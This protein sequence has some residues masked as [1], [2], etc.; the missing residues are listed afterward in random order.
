MNWTGVFLITILIL[1]IGLYAA[2]C[3]SEKLE[4]RRLDNKYNVNKF[5]VT[6]EMGIQYYAEILYNHDKW[7][8]GRFRCKIYKRTLKNETKFKDKLLKDSGINM[9]DYDYD[10]IKIVRYSIIAYEEMHKAEFL[11]LKHQQEAMKAN[12][13]LF[14]EWDGKI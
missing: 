6:S 5:P 3:I 8:G 11:K 1:S 7:K 9:E 12:K 2:I 13:K 4:N 10:Y 14:N